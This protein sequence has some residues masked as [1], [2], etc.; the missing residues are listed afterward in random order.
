LNK[1]KITIIS[2][3]GDL[4]ESRGGR[5]RLDTLI[6]L[7]RK[8]GYVSVL[9]PTF[10]KKKSYVLDDINYF[11]YSI[12]FLDLWKCFLG[13]LSGSPISQAI[14]IRSKMQTEI[15]DSDMT[16][17]HLIRTY[18]EAYRMPAKGKTYIDICESLSENFEKR[19]ELM[20][21]YSLKRFF[22]IF[23]A[24]RLEKLERKILIKKDINFVFITKKDRLFSESSRVLVLPNLNL[25]DYIKNITTVGNYFIFIGHIDYEPN[26]RAIINFS[27]ILSQLDSSLKFRIIGRCSKKNKIFLSH[28]VNILLEGYVDDVSN[29][30]SHAIAGVAII[31]NGTG[32]Q[33]K[34]LDYISYGIPPLVNSEVKFAFPGDLPCIELDNSEQLVKFLPKLL[35]RKWRSDFSKKCKI[36]INKYQ[37]NINN[38][39]TTT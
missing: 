18:S 22:Y 27:L 19:A 7:N 25:N 5:N 20:S 6:L 31:H 4:N 35:N 30:I 34:V 15:N 36:Y 32:L 38:P 8:I 3:F 2:T 29:I 21:R 14:F 13:I 1:P 24:V 33:N 10:F 11:F 37:S 9:T 39:F 12:S 17:F 26:L 16:I 28:Y 23:E